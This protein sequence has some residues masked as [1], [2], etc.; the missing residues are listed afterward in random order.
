MQLVIAFSF[1]PSAMTSRQYAVVLC[2]L[3]ACVV[4]YLIYKVAWPRDFGMPVRRKVLC[5]RLRIVK[6]QMAFVPLWWSDVQVQR[7]IRVHWRETLE[8]S[9]PPPPPPAAQPGQVGT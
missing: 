1:S 3:V 4:L 9:L 8:R 2:A 6:D 7:A 5:R